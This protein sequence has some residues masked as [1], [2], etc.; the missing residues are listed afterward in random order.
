MLY[1][2]KLLICYC[3]LLPFIAIAQQKEQ[4]DAVLAPYIENQSF[5]GV[6]LLASDGKITY[7]RAVGFRD[8]ATQQPIKKTDLFELASVS[9]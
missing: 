9:K 6:V 7:S 4:I 2:K 5:S 3:L 8:I 1:S